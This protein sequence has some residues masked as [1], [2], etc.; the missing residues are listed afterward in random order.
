MDKTNKVSSFLTDDIAYFLGLIVGRGTIIKSRELK[1]LVIGFPYKNLKAI[2]P[3]DASR[4]FDNH[5][6]LSNSLDIIV[7]RLQKLGLDVTK[8]NNQD[9]HSINLVIMWR[10]PDLTWQF[11]NYLLNDEH[12]DYHDFRIPKCIFESDKEIQKEFLRGLFDVTGHA[13]SSNYYID[14]N[15]HRVYLEMDFRNWFLVLDLWKLFEVV[16]IPVQTVNFGHPNFRDKNFVKPPGFWAKEHQFKIFAN[17]F[18]SIGS[19]LEHKQLVLADMAS[20]CPEGLGNERGGNRVTEKPPHPEE[21]SDK[22]PEFLRNKHFNH[23]S[24]LL[25]ELEQNDSIK[26]YANL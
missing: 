21:Q 5:L 11:L 6:Y 15:K 24:E 13:R 20:M 16:G 9:T 23:Y 10:Y 19:Y 8:D 14:R 22:L 18:L 25:T 17:Q 2:S 4:V 1:K 7:R 3:L 26:P 12:T